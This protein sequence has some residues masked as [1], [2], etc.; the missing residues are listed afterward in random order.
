MNF[1]L[2]KH[3]FQHRPFILSR[4]IT[5]ADEDPQAM[6]NQLTRWQKKGLLVSLRKG[7]YLLNSQDRKVDID[8]YTVAN[9]LYE[10]SYVSLESALNFYGLI[11]ERVSDVTSV[12]TRKTLQFKNDLGNFLY[13]HIQPR[14]FRGFQKAGEGTNS[15]F[16]AEPEKAVV[17]FLYLNLSRFNNDTREVLEESYRFQNIEDLDPRRLREMAGLFHTKKLMRVVRDLTR[18][19]EEEA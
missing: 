15:F 3:Q 10:P 18:W 16:M 1:L 2:F 4:D 19:I 13:Q 9:I 5:A 11:P 17:D 14:A 12:S 6:R 8:R 7:M